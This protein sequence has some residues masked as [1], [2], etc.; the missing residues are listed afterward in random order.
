MVVR[1]VELRVVVLAVGVVAPDLAD[2]AP[3]ARYRAIVRV[4]VVRR[5]STAL[6]V[7]TADQHTCRRRS[8]HRR[9][10]RNLLTRA[11]NALLPRGPS[12]QERIAAID[13]IVV[14]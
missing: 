9:V 1:N 6:D 8:W 10:V 5:A 12:A 2:L 13:Q 3:Q 14:V 4:L 11:E 7:A